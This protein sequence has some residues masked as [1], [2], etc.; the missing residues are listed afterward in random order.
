MTRPTFGTCDGCGEYGPLGPCEACYWSV[1]EACD[2]A[3]EPD[4][5]LAWAMADGWAY[6]AIMAVWPSS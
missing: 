5:A 1:C 6:A 4:C 3:H 2:L